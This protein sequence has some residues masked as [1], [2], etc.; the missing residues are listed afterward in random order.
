MLLYLSKATP[1]KKALISAFFI[2]ETGIIY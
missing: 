2:F 1:T